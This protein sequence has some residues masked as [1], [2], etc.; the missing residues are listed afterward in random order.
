MSFNK[1]EMLTPG[2]KV[3]SN[4]ENKAGMIVRVERDRQYGPQYLVSFYAPDT[5]DNTNPYEQY[6]TQGKHVVP[7]ASTRPAI[8]KENSRGK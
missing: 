4:A 5:I 8:N 2:T 3:W 1:E 7:F 6:W